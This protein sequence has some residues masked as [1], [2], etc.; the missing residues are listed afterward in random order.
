M[1]CFNSECSIP[2]QWVSVLAGF[3]SEFEFDSEFDWSS[4][5]DFESTF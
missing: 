3:D 4:I 5:Q 1:I 2:I